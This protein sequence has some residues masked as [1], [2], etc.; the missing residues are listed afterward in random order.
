MG[1]KHGFE[2]ISATPLNDSLERLRGQ[3]AA[4]SSRAELAAFLDGWLCGPHGAD[5]CEG[6]PVA[7]LL[8][9]IAWCLG[10]LDERGGAREQQPSWG[11]FG[12][13]L[14]AAV[15]YG[16]AEYEEWLGCRRDHTDN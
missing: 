7:P 5:N 4:I 13:I 6:S 10:E 9:A 12:Q 15:Y 8:N 16:T 14:L 11:L 1:D 2:L 3:A